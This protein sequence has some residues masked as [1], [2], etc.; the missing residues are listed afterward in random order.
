M[1][2]AKVEVGVTSPR[3]SAVPKKEGSEIARVPVP[4]RRA[5]VRVAWSIAAVA[6]LLTVRR[7][8]MV[9][10]P[11]ATTKLVPP[12]SSRLAAEKDEGRREPS[13]T[14]TDVPVKE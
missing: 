7:E 10:V 9:A 1:A 2:P 12:T 8:V 6:P 5:T 4:P 14:V 13:L 11:K 3:V